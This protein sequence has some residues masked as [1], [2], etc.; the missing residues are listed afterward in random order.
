MDA[1]FITTVPLKLRP[2]WHCINIY[3][4]TLSTAVL[5]HDLPSCLELTT[6]HSS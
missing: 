1:S 4:M 3:I 5:R 2:D 6:F